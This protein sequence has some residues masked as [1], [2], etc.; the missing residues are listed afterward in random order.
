MLNLSVRLACSKTAILAG[1]SNMA[2]YIDCL[3]NLKEYINTDVALN[4]L[5]WLANWSGKQ[6]KQSH[7]GNMFQNS[8]LLVH[9]FYMSPTLVN[10]LSINQMITCF[11][12]LMVATDMIEQSK[13]LK[14]LSEDS[15]MTNYVI[16]QACP[17][18]QNPS[19][20][21]CRQST[22]PTISCYNYRNIQPIKKCWNERMM[23]ALYLYFIHNT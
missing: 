17:F 20:L 5:F 18:M 8:L 13:N 19:G 9:S 22:D 11:R 12:A 4:L 23:T 7:F 14:L 15:K 6:S 3:S 16:F 1:N 21:K 2:R 10:H